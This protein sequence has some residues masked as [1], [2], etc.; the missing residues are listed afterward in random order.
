MKIQLN[1]VGKR[2]R[3]EWIIQGINLSLL[4]PGTYA[5][6]G[7]NGSGKSTLLKLISGYLS[8]SSGKLLYTDEQGK[9]ISRDQIYQRVV[10]AAPYIDLIE[11]FSMVEV[12]EF[13]QQFT[14]F[15][16]NWPI[17]R[18]I[19]DLHLPI[20]PKA[21][22]QQYSSG[23]KQR[24]KLAMAILSTSQLLLLDEPTTNLDAQGIRWYQELV[25]NHLQDRMV[26]IASNAEADFHFCDQ[27]INILQYKK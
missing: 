4:C 17:P 1:N 24:L 25:Q 27:Q 2:F 12:L 8:P 6:T 22:I 20:S 16:P 3:Y 23:M 26:I 19:S 7:P 13:H 21:P 18:I 10:F 15:K 11:S 5:V 9:D 14:P